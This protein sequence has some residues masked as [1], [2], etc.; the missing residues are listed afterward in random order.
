LFIGASDEMVVGRRQ[1]DAMRPHVGDLEIH[2]IED[3][4]HWSQQE[5]PD[6]VNAVMLEWMS[7]RYPAA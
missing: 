2:T 5:K 4:G 3:C 7:R 1:V 6:E